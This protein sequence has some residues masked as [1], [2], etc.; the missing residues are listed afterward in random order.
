MGDSF[1]TN[2]TIAVQVGLVPGLTVPKPFPC[3]NDA[4]T[5]YGSSYQC[6]SKQDY[7][8]VTVSAQW[9]PI[10]PILAFLGSISL[11]STSSMRL[12]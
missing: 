11:S 5:N 12:S 8:K 10:T 1:E 7:V 2:E 6:V 4:G 3:A 9:S